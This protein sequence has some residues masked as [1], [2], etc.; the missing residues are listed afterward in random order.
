[1]L[2]INDSGGA[3]NVGHSS[4]VNVG[5]RLLSFALFKILVVLMTVVVLI[6]EADSFALFKIIYI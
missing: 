6:I 5:R 3:H 1:M 4:G 2:G